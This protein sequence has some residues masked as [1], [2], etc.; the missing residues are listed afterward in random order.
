VLAYA[1]AHGGGTVAVREQSG[2]AACA[3]IQ[4]GA[5][6]AGIGGFSGQESDPSIAW[7]ASEVASGNIRFVD[8]A[9]GAFG[10][11]GRGF[12]GFGGGFAGTGGASG[13]AP[14]GGGSLFGGGGAGR[15]GRR[16]FA[17]GGGLGPGGTRGASPTAG[18]RPG[19]TAIIA[20]AERACTAVSSTTVSGLYDCR[21]KAAAL[22]AL[23]T[24]G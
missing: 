22:R 15:L 1:K 3:I 18:V 21:G 16:G 2:D 13:R 17:P 20:A 14:G 6:V 7:L 19:A 24:A 10:G 5:H 12:P 4:D 23:A 9:A 8:T 11:F